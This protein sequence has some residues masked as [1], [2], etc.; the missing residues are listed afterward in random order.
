MTKF[1]IL[2]VVLASLALLVS[3]NT[4]REQRRLQREANDL[5]RANERLAKRQL[6]LIQEGEVRRQKA[7]VELEMVDVG[8]HTYALIFTN[9]GEAPALELAV[10]VPDDIE[11]I[12]EDGYRAK[13]P[14]RLG[15]GQA[16]KTYA[17]PHLET[18]NPFTAIVTWTN[19]D[20]S[21]GENEVLV[22]W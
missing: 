11:G 2:S 9:R 12:I 14:K 1:E 7:Q 18:A 13:L 22:T 3:L 19:L 17:A 21:A 15:P 10:S 4:W 6:D 8:N 20:G 16:V 5:Q